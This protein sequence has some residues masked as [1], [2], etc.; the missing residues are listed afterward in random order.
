MSHLLEARV[1]AG[2]PT[3]GTRSVS[4]FCLKCD[5]VELEWKGLRLE[6]VDM[7]EH[8]VDKVLVVPLR[9]TASADER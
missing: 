6:V 5:I 9:P 7:D 4:R 3:A 8:R 1:L 2:V